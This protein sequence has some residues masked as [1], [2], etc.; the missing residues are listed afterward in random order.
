MK[1]CRPYDTHPVKPSWVPPPLACDAHCHIFG[2]ADRFPY[3]PERSYTPT[4]AGYD[5]LRA[6]HDF[7]GLERAVL[8]QASCH[9][10]DNTAMLD[11]IARSS[12]RYKGVAMVDAGTPQAEFSRLHAGG[13]RGVRFNFVKHLGGAPDMTFFHET[14]GRLAPLGWHLQLHFDAADIPQFRPL[15][16]ALPVPFII[17]HMARVKASAGVEQPAFVQLLELM[18]GNPKAWVKISGS[19]RVSVGRAPFDDAIPFVRALVEAAADRVLWGT[20]FPHPNISADMPND[21]ELVNLLARAIPD[22]ALR[23]QVLVTNPATLYWAD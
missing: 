12:G 5:Q 9:G 16:D 8:V 7:L 23:T 2:P 11:A 10:S 18:R 22:A 17:D 21:G 4:D 14:V 6:L 15:L 20:D 19:E 13:V 1:P 3:A